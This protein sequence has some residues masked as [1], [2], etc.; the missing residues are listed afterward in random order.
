MRVKIEQDRKQRADRVIAL[1]RLGFWQLK[2]ISWLTQS[3]SPRD[4]IS[5]FSYEIFHQEAGLPP[6][7]EFLQT[8]YVAGMSEE[9]FFHETYR[10][11]KI[12][13]A[14]HVASDFIR[15]ES[16]NQIY[17]DQRIHSVE[18]HNKYSQEAGINSFEVLSWACRQMGISVEDVFRGTAEVKKIASYARIMFALDR[19][20]TWNKENPTDP[21][22]TLSDVARHTSK[23]NV[24]SN[25]LAED[26]YRSD[27]LELSDLLPNERVRIPRS[28]FTFFEDIRSILR[29]TQ[30]WLAKDLFK[31]ETQKF[32]DEIRRSKIKQ[33]LWDE[34]TRVALGI[35]DRELQ[36]ALLKPSD[37]RVFQLLENLNHVHRQNN[38]GSGSRPSLEKVKELKELKRWIKENFSSEIMSYNF[39]KNNPKA[40]D[41]LY[42]KLISKEVK[43]LGDPPLSMGRSSG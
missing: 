1:W 35:S 15:M 3:T 18:T 19:I 22:Q 12:F 11:E 39:T 28:T 4:L 34:L 40:F 29:V 5:H 24:Q 21:V 6:K 27:F 37:S 41:E 9:Q 23:L 17:P 43:M 16:W 25:I 38:N 33:P 14:W 8:L 2:Y 26:I 30:N 7:S 36:S 42:S 10:L 20:E 13:S 31:S 32:V